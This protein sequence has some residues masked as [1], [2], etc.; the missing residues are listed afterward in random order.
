MYLT[1]IK[2]AVILVSNVAF[3]TLA[4]RIF[5]IQCFL[6][7][8]ICEKG[9]AILALARFAKNNLCRGC[10]WSCTIRRALASTSSELVEALY[11]YLTNTAHESGN[12]RNTIGSNAKSSFS[13]LACEVCDK[14]VSETPDLR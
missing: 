12:F 14:N 3:L 2:S 4:T 10:V 6:N 8:I 5:G 13:V 7:D 11:T 9:K 1:E